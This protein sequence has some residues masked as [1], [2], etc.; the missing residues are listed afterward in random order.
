MGAPL[1]FKDLSSSISEL[2]TAA[3]VL[4]GGGWAYMK[5]VRG[6]TFRNRAKLDL[7]VEPY[8]G[9]RAHALLV[10]VT[11]HN[12]GA[13]RIELGLENEKFVRVDEVLDED[14]TAAGNVD[15]DAGPPVMLTRL[16]DAHT[17]LEPNET[18]SDQVLVPVPPPGRKVLA[19]RVKARVFAPR[20]VGGRVGSW[21]ARMRHQ[22]Q[23]DVKGWML[24]SGQTWTE[25]VILPVGLSEQGK[26]VGSGAPTDDAD[27][28]AQ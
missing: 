1:S 10:E 5:Y 14:W 15:W 2:V 17:W 8:E 18:I 7:S 26:E 23:G 12:D 19:Y 28:P 24:E 11:M 22:K 6:R 13:S 27:V 21:L 3:A 9:R 25:F 4:I 20:T 16:F